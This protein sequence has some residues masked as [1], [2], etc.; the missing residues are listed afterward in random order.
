MESVRLQLCNDIRFAASALAAGLAIVR[1][2]TLP[3]RAGAAAKQ[4]V[5]LNLCTD[6]FVM[7]LAKVER[8]AAV[9]HLQRDPRLSVVSQ[10]VKRLRGRQHAVDGA[11]TAMDLVG[12]EARSVLELSGGE[13]AG[14][15]IARTLTQETPLLIADEPV[16][17]EAPREVLTVERLATAYGVRGHI[18]DTADGLS[19]VATWPN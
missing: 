15:I 11:L 12:F 1:G 17:D 18:I 5:S 6:Q 13:G 9:I 19:V 14:V 4:I 10:G 3:M 16:A 8:I 2:N 7:M